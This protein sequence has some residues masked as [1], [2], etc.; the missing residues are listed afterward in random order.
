MY[1]WKYWVCDFDIEVLNYE[2]NKPHLVD[3][4][5]HSISD[6]YYQGV[7]SAYQYVY[8]VLSGKRIASQTEIAMC[9]RFCYDLMREDLRF[10]SEE[11]NL[12]ISIMNLL[13]HP[14]GKLKGTRLDL[15]RWMIFILANIFGWYYSDKAHSNLRSSR[16][17]IENIV[18]VPR[19]N[20]KTTFSAGVTIINT[21]LTAN[22]SPIATTSATTTQ[23]ARIAFDDIAAMINSSATMKKYFEVLRY[24]IR[25]KVNEGRIFCTSKNADAFNGFRITTGI[26]DEWAAHPDGEITDAISTG[27]QSSVD[28]IMLYISTAYNNLGYGFDQFKASKEIAFNQVEND[29]AFVAI[30]CADDSD[31]DN[32]SDEQVWIKANPSYGHAVIPAGLENAYTKSLTN[33][34]AKANFLIKHLNVFYTFDEA[35]FINAT[36]LLAC[37]EHSLDLTKYQDKECYIGLDLASVDDL[38]SAVLIFPN[39]TGGID[40]FHR[41][42]LP[43][44]ALLDLKPSIRDRYLKAKNDGELIVTPTEVTD[45]N[46]IKFDILDWVKR[47]NVQSISIDAAAGGA[48]FAFDMNEE[49]GTEIVA[50]KQGF[51][52]SEP[53]VLFQSLVK[54][55]KVRYNDSLLEWGI[56]N[57]LMVQ[58]EYGDVRITKSKIDPTRKIDP[59]IAMIIGLSQTIL[60]ESKDSIYESQEIRFL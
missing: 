48:R 11:V 24:E 2:V 45:F 27:T 55:T 18:F 59:C 44:T 20:A 41:S 57:S 17:F 32:Y 12:A 5:G 43:E 33:E 30:Y 49:H 52:L 47:F 16:R 3:N 38:S 29:R 36:D 60:Q 31:I 34:A 23:Q 26:V 54:E 13:C 42:Y 51:G 28:P 4:F 15:M 8:N 35:G 58:G 21:L 53:S 6:E 14:K 7:E 10:D 50:V 56:V 19:G 22:G 37:R 39:E 46:Y 25:C 9:E 1:Q 40:V